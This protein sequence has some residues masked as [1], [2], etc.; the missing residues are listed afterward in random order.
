[1]RC[2]CGADLEYS[3]CCEPLIEGRV[4]APTAEA[5]M[6][7]R[8][9]A[10]VHG[11]VDYLVDTFDPA[12]RKPGERAAVE[13]WAREATWLGLTVVATE[14]GGAREDTGIVE[15]RA[16]YRQGGAERV[17]HERSRFR[18]TNGR[19]FY[20][21]GAA[22]T[23]QPVKR[24]VTAGRNDPCPCQSGRKYKKCCGLTA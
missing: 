19:W 23:P 2:A 4:E 16:R 3:N 20:L 8:Y 14:G 11:A 5:L 18:R 21:D 12:T 17:H 1:M 24:A 13:R 10:Y 7:S 15:F 6:R 22:V 9:S